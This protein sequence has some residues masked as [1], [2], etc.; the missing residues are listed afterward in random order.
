MALVEV[1]RKENVSVATVAEAPP[2]P[3]DWTSAL[4]A[5]IALAMLGAVVSSVPSMLGRR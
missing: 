3:S 5:M 2:P 4:G 1:D